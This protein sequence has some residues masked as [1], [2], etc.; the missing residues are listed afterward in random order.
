M[1][2]RGPGK[3]MVGLATKDGVVVRTDR[4][5]KFMRGWTIGQVLARAD[6]WRWRVD[7]DADEREQLARADHR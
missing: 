5:L 4:V 7:L 2:V 6:R 1:I 3:V